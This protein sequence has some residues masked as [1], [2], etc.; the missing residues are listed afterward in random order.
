MR[1]RLLALLLV[2][3]VTVLLL[4]ASVVGQRNTTY[5]EAR[6]ASELAA[7][8]QSVAVVDQRLGEE[9]LAGTK[10]IEEPGRWT[11]FLVEEVERTDESLRDLTALATDGNDTTVIAVVESFGEALK[12]RSDI[13]EGTISP[14]QLL[15]R[16]AGMR[17]VLLDVLSQRARLANGSESGAPLRG[18]FAMIDARSAH[19]NERLATEL[20]L[21]YDT[22]A[23]GQHTTAVGAIII[24]RSQ[25]RVA[26]AEQQRTASITARSDVLDL[27]REA[28]LLDDSIPEVD[29]GVYTSASDTWLRI[30]NSE[31][32]AEANAVAT[33]LQT[34]EQRAERDRLV[35][36]MGVGV[37]LALALLIAGLVS[38]KLVH[39]V[40]LIT[41][42][43]E[44]FAAG[45]L[46]FTS[47]P[48]DVAG[49]DEIAQLSRV[50]DAMAR[51]VDRQARHDELTGLRNRKSIL[52]HWTSEASGARA[53][54][55]AVLAIDLDDFKPINDGLGHHAGDEALRQ[56]ARRIE[57]QASENNG[58]AGRLGGDEFLVVLQ[59]LEHE[60][61]A[62]EIGERILAELVRPIRI[63]RASVSVGASVGVAVH[64]KGATP[65]ELLKDADD[66]LY[67]AKANGRGQLIES[68]H[69]LRSRLVDER[70]EQESILQALSNG[71][72]IP[73]F[74]P[75]W[76]RGTAVTAFEALVR[77][78]RPDGS[79]A[80]PGAIIPVIESQG[81]LS[82]LDAQVFQRVCE[83]I[84]EWT[85]AGLPVRP[86]S[87]NTSSARIEDP[88]F[89]SDVLETLRA[90]G[91]PSELILFEVTESGLMTDRSG[92]VQRLQELRDH[93][94][95]IGADDFGTGYSSLS[96]LQDLPVD[97]LKL[98]RVFIDGIDTNPANQ[99][100][101]RNVL[102]LATELGLEVVAEGVET[103]AE[104]DW[105]VEHETPILQGFLLGRPAPKS[106]TAALLA[107]LR[108]ASPVT[109]VPETLPDS[110]SADEVAAP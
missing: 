98:D 4:A 17:T 40:G 33:K 91:C 41:D 97:A 78:K 1:S 26:A 51:K 37:A 47:E 83:T 45:T 3:A 69:E 63:D 42:R 12:Y 30:M 106:E 107:S 15:D 59:G 19:L 16:Y 108:T 49:R 27:F 60:S 46:S 36:S 43:A 61:D 23:P 31:I 14:L 85:E 99:A 6:D 21:T 110:W 94:I 87:V 18:L 29:P 58:L 73:Y 44:A 66:A 90:T 39:R 101:V 82:A 79:I 68:D 48:E 88:D 67:V 75:L 38:Y 80:G 35:T 13:E 11:Q 56:T 103:R 100:I 74:Q 65:V 52:D 77:W 89:V 50:F 34:A 95:R 93:G 109:P 7:L 28:V 57:R 32:E 70:Q 53:G 105:L 55:V 9:A 102:S 22:W 92:N 25:I 24:Q 86:I 96:Y 84:V 76:H 8:A 54:S 81:L 5:G 62:L 2:P 64:R 72:F 20:A 10:A 71:D 104:Y